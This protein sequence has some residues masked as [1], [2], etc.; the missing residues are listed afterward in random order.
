L[1]NKKVNERTGSWNPRLPPDVAGL[2]RA[3]RQ[4]VQLSLDEVAGLS[5]VPPSV[6][7]A[8]EEGTETGLA[9]PR[10]LL[11]TLELLAPCLRLSPA[12]IVDATLAAWASS[13]STGEGT[14]G[15]SL[16]AAPEP[17]TRQLKALDPPTARVEAI[18]GEPQEVTSARPG[19]SHSS[20]EQPV[21]SGTQ[22]PW[23]DPS[24]H[25]TGRPRGIAVALL[26]TAAALV[27]SLAALGAAQAGLFTHHAAPPRP[28]E[29]ASRPPRPGA[30]PL[31]KQGVLGEN[32]ASYMVTTAPYE[33]TVA[34]SQPSWV[35]VT[36]ATGPPVFAGTIGAGATRTFKVSSS[37]TIELGAGGTNVSLSSGGNRQ[38]TLVPPHAPFTYQLTASQ[39]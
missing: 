33:V 35:Q 32:T 13:Y 36:T 6:I 21:F 31:L 5:H 37:I 8:L 14:P 19:S 38:Q 16:L 34:A 27:C 12:D 22:L 9:K 20:A 11:R 18:M 15:S 10:H 2:L 17:A 25:P 1:V 28:T 23:A 29:A 24:H 3:G 30:E 39:T 26:L 7:G 4:Q